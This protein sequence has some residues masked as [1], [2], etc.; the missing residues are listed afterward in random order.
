MFHASFVG[1]DDPNCKTIPVFAIWYPGP[2]TDSHLDCWSQLPSVLWNPLQT[3][4]TS[5]DYMLLA[6]QEL[7]LTQNNKI[8]YSAT[9]CLVSVA[10]SNNK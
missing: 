8:N 2:G 3:A 6:G 5:D 4:W 9:F 1:T 10:F 7:H